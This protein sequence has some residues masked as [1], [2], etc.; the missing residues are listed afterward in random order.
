MIK[1]IDKGLENISRK[2]IKFVLCSVLGFSVVIFGER[3]EQ[4]TVEIEKQWT[5]LKLVA[6]NT[7]LIVDGEMVQAKSKEIVKNIYDEVI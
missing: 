7:E 3:E 1:L 4:E 5:T 6:K 2:Y